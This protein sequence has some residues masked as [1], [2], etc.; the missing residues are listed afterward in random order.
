MVKTKQ[1]LTNY[2]QLE[3]TN[4]KLKIQASILWQKINVT[5]IV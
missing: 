4:V 2:K 1:Q 3:S 5:D